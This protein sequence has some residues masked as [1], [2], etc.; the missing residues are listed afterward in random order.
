MMQIIV[1]NIR[2]MYQQCIFHSDCYD[3][4]SI[5][6]RWPADIDNA[7]EMS[8]SIASDSD[9]AQEMAESVATDTDNAQE[10]S[11]SVHQI[12]TTLA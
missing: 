10:M 9:N 1:H 4:C 3:Y 5:S 11:I 8:I 6:T 7:K 2:I 12:L